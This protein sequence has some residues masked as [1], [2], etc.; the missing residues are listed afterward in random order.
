MVE[1]KTSDVLFSIGPI[2]KKAVVKTSSIFLAIVAI[3]ALMFFIGNIFALEAATISTDKDDYEPGETVLIS[4]EGFAADAAL[5]VRVT[6][7]DDSVVTGDG[8]F[9]DWPAGYDFVTS[10]SSGNFDFSYVLDGILGEY[11]VDV[12]DIDENGAVLA[13]TTFT[14]SE[15]SPTLECTRKGFDFAIEKFE[16]ND[17]TPDPSSDEYDI[18]VT[19][20][21]V[22]DCDS[23]D[24]ESDPAVD[25]VI[26]KEGTLRFVH[27]GGTSG[28]ID[29]DAQNDISH[30]TFCRDEVEV[31]EN[32]CGD[33]EVNQESEQCDDGNT[34]NGDGCDEFC[35]FEELECETA[36]DCVQGELCT[37]VQCVDNECVYD[38]KDD[39]VGP[40]I[41]DLEVSK[42]SEQCKVRINATA[43][44]M[45]SEVVDGEYFLGGGA[46]GTEGTGEEFDSIVELE[47]FISELI[48]TGAIVNDGS[49]NIHVRA[50]DA[51]GNWGTCETTNIQLDCLPPEYPTCE[52]GNEVYNG[53]PDGIV[54]NGMCKPQEKLVCG[55]DPV[56]EANICDSQSR[57]QLAEYFL[58]DAPLINWQGINLSAS[59]GAFDEK[60]EDVNATIDLDPLEDGTHYVY[61]HGKDGQENWGKFD[62]FNNA[63]FIKDTTPPVTMKKIEFADDAYMECDFES[64]NGYDL[65]DGCYYVKSGTSIWLNATDPDPQ[66]TGEFAGDEVITAKIWFSEDCTVDEPN[67]TVKDV[68]YSEVGEDLHFNLTEDS[69]HLIEYWSADACTNEEEHHFELDIVDDKAPITEK[70]VGDH[71]ISCLPEQDDEVLLSGESQVGV[72]AVGDLVH[73]LDVSTFEN[74]G[75]TN[76]CSVGLAFDGSSL[77]YNRCSDQNI[78]QIDPIT[79]AL[80]D[81]FDTNVSYPNAMAYDA[82]RNG[83]W[84]G[85]QSCDQTGMPIYFWDFDDDSVTLEFHV[86][87]GELL[88]LCFTDGLAYNEN[89]PNTADDDE[90]WFSDDID[91]LVGLFRPDGTHVDTFDATDIDSSLS[92]TSGLAVGGSNL[93]LGNNGGGDV[94]RADIDSWTFVDEFASTSDRV[95]DMECDPV[96]FNN[97]EDGFKEVM[98]VRHTPQ[99]VAEDDIITAHEIE[100]GTCGLGGEEPNGEE[101]SEQCE[102]D[103]DYYITSETEINLTCEDQEPH[104]V[105]GETLHW[106]LFYSEDCLDANDEGWDLIEENWEEDGELTL[107]GLQSS[108]H[109]LE[110]WCEDKLGNKEELQVEIDAVD[111]TPPV[112][113]KTIYGPQFGECPP[114]PYGPEVESLWIDGYEYCFVDT[115]T[116]L[117]VDAVD[118]EPHP[119]NDVMCDWY[120]KVYSDYDVLEALDTI[121]GGV[122]IK[123][124]FNI[125]FPEESIHHLW[126]EC[127]DALWNTAEDHEVFIVDKT[128]PVTFK[129]LGRPQFTC[130]DWCYAECYANDSPNPG[131][132]CVEQCLVDECSS[133]EY[134]YVSEELKGVEYLTEYFP[135]WISNETPIWLFAQDQYPHPSGVK[136]LNYR[137]TLVGD[138]ACESV[139]RCQELDGEGEWLQGEYYDEAH[140][141]IEEESCHLIEYWAVD[142]VEKTE[143]VNKQ[144]VY[145]DVTPPTTDKLVGEPKI[146]C[147]G[148]EEQCGPETEWD[149]YYVTSDTNIT[150]S[151]NDPEPHP[152]D[153]S[154]LCFAV[155]WHV[156][157]RECKEAYGEWD[158][159][160]GWCWLTDEYAPEYGDVLPIPYDE[161]DY[162]CVDLEDEE[163]VFNFKEDSLHNLEW[164]CQDALGNKGDVNVEWDNVDNNPPKI[165]FVNPTPD[166]AEDVEMCIQSIVVLIADE[167]SGV[168]ESSIYAELIDENGTVVRN[169]TLEKFVVG[170][171]VTYEAL[172]DKELPEGYYEL[173]VYASDNLGNQANK[174]RTEFLSETI[175]VQFIDPAKCDIDA[176]TGGECWFDFNVCMRG[177]NSINFTMNKFG[178]VVTPEMMSAVIKNSEGDMAQVGLKHVLGGVDQEECEEAGAV[179]PEYVW[180]EEE[181][182][183][184]FIGDAEELPLSCEEINGQTQ[185]SLH[186]TLDGN[187]TSQLGTGVHK[188]DYWIDSFFDEDSPLCE[189]ED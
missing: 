151:C 142:N 114:E 169:V 102:L 139:Q 31:E 29:K 69:C 172:M 152:V 79:G 14:D 42:L 100:P 52:L 162:Y 108:C 165:F 94:F 33:G 5:L 98:W 37:D 90:I 180:D 146:L 78:Y 27:D 72:A 48:E 170:N 184:W 175:H 116:T 189:D 91:D 80:E 13:T 123:A 36:E 173:V 60:C 55:T 124:P 121:E 145:V 18:N 158:E 125:T 103:I 107:S 58:D 136:E 174:S 50:K 43:E 95:E 182:V 160:K 3:F 171:T 84:F 144:C 76:H 155:S 20:D 178:D 168:D 8:S 105:G 83:I 154:E 89:D 53:A 47:E 44:D 92:T 131:Q 97:E 70:V 21:E 24:W 7:P 57:I 186:L 41:T 28:S 143:E 68:L 17:T 32:V 115:A 104:P 101:P 46:C 86:P 1:K 85:S 99:S 110:Y 59:D 159:S 163:F 150:L 74:P 129:E 120:Y 181:E 134:E 176:E 141:E 112:I 56:I 111:N 62:P 65:T 118:P 40:E 164:F 38:F 140:F 75:Y 179:F 22:N 64:A 77:Y 12:L 63:S 137:V 153:H 26:S 88:N 49:L 11:T 93:Y 19:W 161:V 67:W 187:V 10:D 109:K 35:Q 25:G 39:G 81:T 132:E 87:F 106:Q 66:G 133:N 130:Y 138:E 16:C 183:C 82:K 4:G 135:I 126:I 71:K 166:E 122:G 96:T 147:E 157:E 54:L 156:D 177:G 127:Y 117:Q 34:E 185:F 149:A 9:G 148:D 45:C 30:I 167:K 23:V 6:R 51:A 128:P 2:N 15:P 119:V 73:E 188:V 113:T 61:L